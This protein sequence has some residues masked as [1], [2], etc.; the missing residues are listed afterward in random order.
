MALILAS[1][2]ASRLNLLE[3]SGLEVS[4][5][6]SEIKEGKIK[7]TMLEDKATLKEIAM[8][9]AQRKAL[10]VS[11]I[12][13]NDI[14]IGAD[15]ILECDGKLFD[16]AKNKAEALEHLK[17]FRGKQHKLI[18]AVV[19]AQNGA[20]IWSYNTVPTLNM[21]NISDPFLDEYIEKAGNALTKSVGAY[22]L[23]GIGAQLFSRIEG[24]YH[25]ILGLPL[26]PLLEKLRELKVVNE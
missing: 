4:V 15:Q 7:E 11:E 3:S 24:D 10:K 2:S 9:L 20:I 16:K 21:R 22:Y 17:F 5:I 23:E 19:L 12:R 8:A 6:P 13:Y 14:I 1:K 26:I 25:A 18:T